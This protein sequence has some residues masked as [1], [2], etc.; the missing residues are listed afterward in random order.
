MPEDPEK[1]TGTLEKDGGDAPESTATTGT[2][3]PEDRNADTGEPDYKSLYEKEHTLSLQ[4]K[5]KIEEANRLR[6]ENARLRAQMEIGKPATTPQ[7]SQAD[8]EARNQRVAELQRL[9][10]HDPAAAAALE[11]LEENARLRNEVMDA[12]TLAE[13]PKDQRAQAVKLYES[14]R[15]ESMAQVADYM[16]KRDLQAQNEALRKEIEELKQ[17]KRPAS[18]GEPKDKDDVVRTA[19]R[20]VSLPTSKARTTTKTEFDEKVRELHE[21]GDHRGARA[22]QQDLRDRKIVFRR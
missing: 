8:V 9:A 1:T 6:D 12:F 20:D 7:T 11:L 17:G 18:E 10:P 16:G 5:D 21:A 15:F 19:G 14:G 3:T 13:I 22:M 2:P 4:T